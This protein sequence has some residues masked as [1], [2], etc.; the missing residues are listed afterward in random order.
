MHQANIET[1]TFLK[2]FTI[3]DA[4]FFTSVQVEEN[5]FVIAL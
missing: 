3:F 4:H 5:Y 1:L 2:L